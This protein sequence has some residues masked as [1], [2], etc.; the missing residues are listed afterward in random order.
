[1]LKVSGPKIDPWGKPLNPLVPNAPSLYPLKTS[2]NLKIF[3][4]FQGVEKDC[5]GN[6]LVNISSEELK[7]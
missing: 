4:Y 1:M 3:W 6:Q 2:E 7:L 5:I